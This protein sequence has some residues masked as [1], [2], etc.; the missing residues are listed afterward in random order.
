MFSNH[1]VITRHNSPFSEYLVASP[2]GETVLPM[3][4]DLFA[5]E[6]LPLNGRLKPSDRP[7]FGVTLNPER[8]LHRPYPH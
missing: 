2:R 6:P 1:Y 8:Q 4:G 7:G 3:Y 5:D